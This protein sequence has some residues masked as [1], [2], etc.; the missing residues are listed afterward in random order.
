MKL[1]PIVLF[2][3][4]RPSHTRQT[5]E[6][7]QKNE[8]ADGSELFIYSDAAKNNQSEIAVD[9][10]RQYI[11]SI[12]GFR[13]I[14]IIER[15]KNWGLA[16][17]IIDGVSTVVNQYG[18]V[19]VLEDDMVTSPYF[20]NYMNEALDRYADDERVISVHGYVYPVAQVLPEAFFLRGADCWGWATWRRGWRLFNPDGQYL[21][22]ELER[23]N[24]LNA[25]DFNGT[26]P[27]SDM[28]ANQIAGKNDSWAVRWYTSAFLAGKLTLYPGRSLV[29]NI[30]N[31]SSGTHCDAN[32]SHDVELSDSPIDLSTVSVTASE[33]ARGAFESFFRKSND[34]ITD[35]FWR[36]I[37]KYCPDFL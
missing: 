31:D 19:I 18:R 20:L 30:G 3:Y 35:K 27:F 4:N 15:D 1:S 2:V 17:S 33:L 28:L 6:A 7:L 32:L 24:L 13:S 9:E 14:K 10:V 23:Q 5:I 26:Y 12:D 29:H 37:K 16:N 11:K 22:K 8:F 34:S 25:F 36:T 21:L